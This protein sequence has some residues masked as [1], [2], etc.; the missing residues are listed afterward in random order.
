ARRDRP[1]P[2]APRRAALFR[3]PDGRRS[4]SGPE[5]RRDHRQAGLGAGPD[6]ALSRAAGIG[7]TAPRDW[8]LVRDLFHAGLDVPPG[9]R[10]A[11]VVKRADDSRVVDEVMS[12]LDAHSAAGGFLS[13]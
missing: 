1:A 7:M 11:F 13:L 2:G 12:L 9:E 8:E 10:R 5:R 6:L 4:S 3:R